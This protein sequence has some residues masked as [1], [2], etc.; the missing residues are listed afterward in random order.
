MKTSKT[1]GNKTKQHQTNKHSNP[2]TPAY[3]GGARPEAVSQSTIEKNQ[4][5]HT[6]THSP[7]KQQNRTHCSCFRHPKQ[8]RATRKI[9]LG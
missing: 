3:Q 7:P 2:P 5:T 9:M 6:H 1:K 8:K 4:K